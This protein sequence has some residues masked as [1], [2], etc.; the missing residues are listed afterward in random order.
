VSA[1]TTDLNYGI[2][3]VPRPFP[4]A[5][6]LGVQHVLT[7]FGATIAV[8]LLLGGAMDLSGGDMA[9]LISSVFIASGL[10]TVV[11]LTVGTRLPIVQGMSFAFL[12][13]FFAI[14]G[15]VNGAP[16]MRYIAGAII[17]G[18]LV[19]A[20]LGFSGLFGAIRRVISPVVIGP[21]IAII[22]LSLFNA[23]TLQVNTIRGDDG[24]IVATGNWW[25]AIL[26]VAL[27]LVFSLV[28]GPRY[29]TFSLFP[30]LLAVVTVYALAFVLSQIGFF[31]GTSRAFV[32]FSGVGEAPWLRSVVGDR[33]L[34]FPWGTPQFDI[35]FTI[36]VL[37]AYLASAI[38]SVGDYH[39]VSDVAGVPEP[40]APTISR[41]IGAEG[42][43]CIIT[44]L[45]GGFAST[46]YT[47]NIGLVGI[48][49]VASRVVVLLG[50]GVLIVLG[51]IT[52]VG[53]IIAT[54]PAPIVGGVY[55]ALFGL[56]AAVGISNMTR[57]DLTSQRNLLIIGVSLFT[58]LVVPDY[59]G[60]L[61]ADW[62][63]LDQTWLTNLARSIGSS[64]IAVTALLGLLLDNL[65][66]G[67]DAERGLTTSS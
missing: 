47:E 46:S 21:V 12:G 42:I 54:I 15:T 64:G 52:K 3:D 41:G 56:I 57:A 37:A 38:E 7:M 11:Q 62:T 65:L 5:L 14:I 20:A 51:L 28:L 29:R 59:V 24:S 36:A 61:E 1:T 6:V 48:T 22:G 16:S 43:G 19:E 23:A 44:G 9:V 27:I 18:G 55:L 10:A 53:A 31:T 30:I 2:D 60:Q 8:P 17:I 40:D 63:L 66:P 45:V 35:G 25:L 34:L 58:G 32:S 33:S 4:R 49:K 50:A 39:A 67:T 13:P 26:V